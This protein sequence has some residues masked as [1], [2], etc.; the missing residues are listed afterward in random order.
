[1]TVSTSVTWLTYSSIEVSA[2][3]SS[4]ECFVISS[5]NCFSSLNI[6]PISSVELNTAWLEISW[7]IINTNN[8]LGI[9]VKSH[10]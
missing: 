7:N 9:I 4:S 5:T 6:F 8:T 3:S 10:N 2:F 1:M